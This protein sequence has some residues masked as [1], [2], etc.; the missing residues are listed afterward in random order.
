MRT[1][2]RAA[3]ELSVIVPAP[4]ERGAA[5]ALLEALDRSLS[6]IDWE[7]VFVGDESRNAST[8]VAR[9]LAAHDPRVR[10]IHRSGRRGLPPDCI[11]GMPTDSAPHLAVIDGDLRH[12]ETLLLSMLE[13]LRNED[14]DVVIGSRYLHGDGGERLSRP[15]RLMRSI[16]TDVIRLRLRTEITDPLSGFYVVTREFLDRA[17]RRTMGTGPMSL[18]D[19]L[20]AAEG[21]VCSREVPCTVRIRPSGESTPDTLAVWDFAWLLADR[22]IGRLVPVRFVMFVC[23]GLV[24]LAVHLCLL[25]LII[26]WLAYGFIVGQ[27]VATVSTMS[28]NFVLNN[29]FTYWD[30][31]L[32]GLAFVR[33]LFTFYVACAI[34]A[35]INVVVATWVYGFGA[36]WWLAGLVGAMIGAVWNYS[37]S[38]TLTW[39]KHDQSPDRS[40]A[41]RR[42]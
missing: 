26:R 21:G 29:I 39:K 7:V 12:D 1:G 28:L 11:G 23:V 30:V 6:A 19:L 24:G 16:A 8:E 14:L 2:D 10:V 17:V 34:G 41:K 3:R 42:G 36:P 35:V 18:L 27:T 13:A 32:Q 25:G 15:R 40:K 4:N 31:Q 20:M 22:T 33:G 38:A 5:L 37:M 9:D